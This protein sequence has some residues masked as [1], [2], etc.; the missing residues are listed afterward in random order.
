MV[1][2]SG[3]SFC[4]SRSISVCKAANCCSRAYETIIASKGELKLGQHNM[5]NTRNSIPN[6]FFESEK[7]AP[8]LS[9]L[10]LSSCLALLVDSAPL[11]LASHPSLE[12]YLASK[13]KDSPSNFEVT[14]NLLPFPHND[15][16]QK[17][18]K[19]TQPLVSAEIQGSTLSF[20]TSSTVLPY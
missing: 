9:S 2:S 16:S 10:S 14:Q 5:N 19:K 4:L 1:N 15:M 8:Q 17:T 18:F 11:I 12:S 3:T 20:S 6:V 13:N 7:P